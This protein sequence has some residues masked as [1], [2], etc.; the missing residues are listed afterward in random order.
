MDRV[1][2]RLGIKSDYAPGSA[3]HRVPRFDS[4][5]EEFQRTS[6][7]EATGP[8]PQRTWEG[9]CSREVCER[10]IPVVLGAG[11]E[12]EVVDVMAKAAVIVGLTCHF[13]QDTLE[14]A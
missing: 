9:Q 10:D 11:E 2:I 8:S 4:D 6:L 13:R 7:R 12:G 5:I 1:D 3:P 14:G